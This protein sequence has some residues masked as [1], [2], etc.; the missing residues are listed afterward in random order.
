MGYMEKLDNFLMAVNKAGIEFDNEDGDTAV[1]CDDCVGI[2]TKAG[3]QIGVTM[4]NR[5]EKLSFKAGFTRED[6]EEFLN[7][8][9][10][11]VEDARY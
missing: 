4:V 7:D 3:D 6:Y 9:K 5:V 11:E 8:V 2:I 1:I 10:K